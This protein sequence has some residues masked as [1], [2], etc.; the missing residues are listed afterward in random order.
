MDTLPRSA[1]VCCFGE[2]LWDVLPDGPQPG[3]APL[4]VTYHLAKLGIVAALVSRIGNDP[5]GKQLEDLMSRWHLRKDLLQTD[6]SY[7]T[8]RVVARINSDNEVSYEIVF[9]VAWDFIEA[10]FSTMAAVETAD[11]F[12]YGS[13]AARHAVSKDTLFQLLDHAACKVFDINLRPPFYQKDILEV[14]LSRADILKVNHAELEIIAAMFDSNPPAE[15]QQVR[16]L[17]EMFDIREVVVTKGSQGA[18]YYFPEGT[19]HCVGAKVE[20][21]DTIG[22]G[23]SFLAA[24]IA[25]HFQKQAPDVILKKATAMGAFIAGRKGGC[26]YYRLSEYLDFCQQL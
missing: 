26:P 1:A 21:C 4:N 10:D 8:S 3:G 16:S 2:I 17:Q 19:C 14:L 20:V 6:P 9:P 15:E 18:S 7:D 22:S 5:E 12:V 11:Y 25:S 13:L 24:W 23:D